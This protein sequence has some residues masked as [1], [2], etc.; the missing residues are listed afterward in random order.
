V[1]APVAHLPD[2]LIR[3]SPHPLEMREQ[4]ELQRPP[5]LGLGQAALTRLMQ[6]IEQLAI[7][8]DLQ[9]M[10]RAVADPDRP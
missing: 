7:H 9:L 4:G 5:G 10:V 1:Q 3:L 8:V 2:A 6:R